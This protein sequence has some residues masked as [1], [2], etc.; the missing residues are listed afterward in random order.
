MSLTTRRVPEPQDGGLVGQPGRGA[1][2]LGE[3]KAQRHVVQR[4]FHRRVA[5]AEP[6][7]QIVDAQHRLDAERRS[8]GLGPRVVRLDDLRSHSSST[9]AI[10]GV[11]TAGWWGT[12]I[13][14]SPGGGIEKMQGR[15]RRGQAT[16]SPMA[17]AHGA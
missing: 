9:I 15:P 14:S 1:T 17:L 6:L 3:L 13:R 8:P 4:F 2:E 5:Q 10:H 11:P 12:S 16:P 7:L